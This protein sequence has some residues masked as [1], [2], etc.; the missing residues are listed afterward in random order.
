[1]SSASKYDSFIDLGILR[2]KKIHQERDAG[3]NMSLADLKKLDV[4]GL[5]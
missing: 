3:L 4:G 2:N 5:D 1:M